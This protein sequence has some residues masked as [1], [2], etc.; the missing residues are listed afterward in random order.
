MSIQAVAWAIKQQEV[1]DPFCRFVLVCLA[2][3]AGEN[4]QNAF[5]SIATLAKDTGL[6]DSTV[7]RKLQELEETG[8]ITK[9][10]QTIAA[11]H[12]DRAD[13]RPVVY[14]INTRGVT[15][16]ARSVNGVS[17][18]AGRGVTEAPTGCQ[19][20][21]HGVSQLDTQS[22][23]IRREPLRNPPSFDEDF[24]KRFGVTPEEA[25]RIRKGQ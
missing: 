14:D 19:K 25:N 3:Y 16:I 1:K 9:G 20:Q 10:N 4:G 22:E 23:E 11:A 12:I 15:V 17:A 21:V 24:K 8:F 2:N 18:E 5:P 13:R 6:S 7:R